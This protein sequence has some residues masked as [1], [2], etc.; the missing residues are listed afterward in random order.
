MVSCGLA[1]WRVSLKNLSQ[2]SMSSTQMNSNLT[3]PSWRCRQRREHR[4]FETLLQMVPGLEDRLLTGADDG[5]LHVAEMVSPQSRTRGNR[6][7]SDELHVSYRKECLALD[8]M[9]RRASRARS[10]IRSHH[11]A[12]HSAC[13]LRGTSRPI[14]DS[15]TS[16]LVH[17][18]VQR[19]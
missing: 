13:P 4:V 5:V 14:V 1:S 7:T 3:Q 8:L 16:V 17:S 6:H 10:S 19:G 9:I 18:S 2:M 15:I 11:E 12:N